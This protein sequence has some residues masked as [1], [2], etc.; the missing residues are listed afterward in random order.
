MA[1]AARAR[2][3]GREEAEPLAGATASCGAALGIR[4]R[5]ELS[6]ARQT[7]NL[8]DVA[9]YQ[10]IDQNVFGAKVRLWGDAVIDQDRWW[11]Q[12]AAGL[13]YRKNEDFNFIPA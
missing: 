4:N 3:A 11:P 12:V 2:N 13:Q 9:R 8:D 10:T 5:V 6:Y 1:S 7:F